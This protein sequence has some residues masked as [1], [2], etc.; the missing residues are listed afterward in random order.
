LCHEL[1]HDS[2]ESP[3]LSTAQRLVNIFF[4]LKDYDSLWPCVTP[5]FKQ[6]AKG[7]ELELP[8]EMLTGEE[9]GPDF[10]VLLTLQQITDLLQIPFQHFQLRHFHQTLQDIPQPQFDA[11]CQGLAHSATL[12]L[13]DISALGLSRVDSQRLQQ[14]AEAI[15]QSPL[16]T[17]NLASNDLGSMSAEQLR[18][19]TP[20]FNHPNLA[21]LDISHNSFHIQ[22]SDTDSANQQRLQRWHELMDI[23]SKANNRLQAL[24]NKLSFFDLANNH[25]SEFLQLV[26]QKN[27][28]TLNLGDDIELALAGQGGA[29]YVLWRQL[30]PCVHQLHLQFTNLYQMGGEP[31]R[32][33]L[34]RVLCEQLPN[35]SLEKLDLSYA[36]IRQRPVKAKGL[37]SQAQWTTFTNTLA[38]CQQ[39]AVG[40]LWVDLGNNE[41]TIAD[42]RQAGQALGWPPSVSYAV[43]ALDYSGLFPPL[44]PQQASPEQSLYARLTNH[45]DVAEQQRIKPEQALFQAMLHGA[46]AQA[47]DA[48]QALYQAR[49]L[50][51]QLVAQG[52]LHREDSCEH[53]AKALFMKLAATTN[54][55]G[56]PSHLSEPMMH[57]ILQA[58][59]DFYVN[60]DEASLQACDRQDIDD[61]HW[62]ALHHFRQ[63]SNPA[64]AYDGHSDSNSSTESI[65]HSSTG[66]LHR[67]FTTLNPCGQGGNEENVEEDNSIVPVKPFS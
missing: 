21:D 25:A 33:E 42:W 56:F 35:T 16:T 66:R 15:Q 40:P 43:H 39:R 38:Q 36:G 47:N 41:L 62:Q 20:A 12:R 54:H 19:L 2:H 29:W 13:L 52:E 63:P 9:F 49:Q 7:H 27:I 44:K 23:L 31:W 45:P 26:Q 51:F 14:L 30:P 17:L 32:E 67:F 34:W 8:I 5:I 37:I 6:Q 28:Q 55:G 60:A 50:F 24:H 18:A 11:L 65:S 57:D 22:P 4:N 58:M 53:M 46:K 64:T 1:E 61:K 10:S 59:I 48:I 3:I